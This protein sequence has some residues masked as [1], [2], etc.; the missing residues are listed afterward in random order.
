MGT[1]PVYFLASGNVTIS[2]VVDLNGGRGHNYDA[3]HIP[4]FAGAGGYSGGIGYQNGV[5]AATAG[6]G[7]G[8]GGA[9]MTSGGFAAG[10]GAGGGY[11]TQ[12]TVYGC[13]SGCAV[14]GKAYGNKYLLPLYGGSGGGGGYYS[15]NGSG[16]GAGGG[17]LLI[18]CSGTIQLN[19]G[20]NILAKG[21]AP[22]NQYTYGSGGGGSGGA[23]RLAAN[24]IAGSGVVD[25]WSGSYG[26]SDGYIRIEAY[27]CTVPTGNFRPVAQFATPGLPL[28]PTAAI[29]PMVKIVSFDGIAVPSNPFGNY[30][31]PDVTINKGDTTLV[32]IKAKNIPLGTIVNVTMNSED[33]GSFSFVTTPLVGT[34]D[35]ATATARIKIPPGYSRFTC[36]ASW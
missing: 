18:A 34:L 22:G 25:V 33:E 16:G 17:A 8:G 21:G 26:A 5:C 6:E 27:T 29:L 13:S 20:G 10:A 3:V 24:T 35:S 7:P 2:G 15:I 32:A 11:K 14:F 31:Q 23:V 1:R 36:T 9:G 4:S 19:F 28:F 12:G 30:T